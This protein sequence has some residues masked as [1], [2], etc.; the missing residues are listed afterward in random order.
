MSIQ[1]QIAVA[2]L[3]VAGAFVLPEA[4]GM[5]QNPRLEPSGFYLLGGV[6]GS[7]AVFFGTQ[8]ALSAVKR[9]ARS[10]LLG[11]WIMVALLLLGLMELGAA[12]SRETGQQLT[13]YAAGAL[14][15]AVFA[16]ALIEA[17][18]VERRKKPAQPPTT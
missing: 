15:I 17:N 2:S 1:R 7:L 14:P 16:L 18:L 6:M 12:N 4:A 5:F 3:I 9:G 13:C 8:V 10:L 11:F